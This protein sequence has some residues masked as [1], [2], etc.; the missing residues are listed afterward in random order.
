MST[1]LFALLDDVAAIA[2]IA[3][4]SI[5]DVAGQAVDASSKAAGVVIDDAAVTPKYV[6]GFAAER[7]LPMIARIAKGSLQTKLLLL[8]PGAL[9][10]SAVAPWA[11]NPLLV[12][13]GAYLCFEGFEKILELVT[14]H[15]ESTSDHQ[16]TGD[17]ATLE[18]QRVKGALRTD[19]ILSAEIM[20]VTLASVAESPLVTQAVVMAMVGGLITVFVY[21][22]VALIVKA[23]DVGVVL[24][25]RGERPLQVVGR[26]LVTGMPSFLRWL[27][28]VGIAAMLWVGGGI[29]LHALA[30]LGAPGPEHHIADAGAAVGRLVAPAISG[31]VVW[32]VKAALSALVGVMVG[33]MVAGA[34]SILHR[35]RAR[36]RG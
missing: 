20:A 22:V 28:L 25:R 33:A 32:G 3:A 4:A 29:V 21:G 10:M 17:G 31:G 26:A 16:A 23:D 6:V 8:L 27:S 34:L 36:A 19:V 14:G 18:D 5:D 9:L 30:G 35:L 24:A 15:D 1:G 2:K 11:L 12:V 13:G 7:E